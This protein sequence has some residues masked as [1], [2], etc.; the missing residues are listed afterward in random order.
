MSDNLHNHSRAIM[1]G[2]ELARLFM[3]QPKTPAQEELE[4]ILTGIEQGLA[5]ADEAMARHDWGRAFSLLTVVGEA[6]N[7]VW[8]KVVLKVVQQLARNN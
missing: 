7:F 8:D 6:H 5:Q 2:V 4:E 1:G 3:Q